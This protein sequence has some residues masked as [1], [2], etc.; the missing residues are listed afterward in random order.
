MNVFLII[1]RKLINA[2]RKFRCIFFYY[3]NKF[4]FIVKGVS[5]GGHLR[6][7][8]SLYIQKGLNSEIVI[9]DNFTFTSGECFNPLC[10][11][12]RGCIVTEPGSS[13]IIGN[14]VG[15]SSP[16][17]WAHSK[18]TIGNR[19]NIGGDCILMDSDAHSLN[20][21]DRRDYQLD[22]VNKKNSPISIGDDV[23]I[24]ARC[25]ILKGVTIGERSVIGSGSVVTRSI[26]ADCI[27]GGNPCKIIKYFNE[28]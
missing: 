6:V 14:N 27:A 15:M 23:L 2:P 17:V 16:C 9:G 12:V 7:S 24:G 19:V 26:P 10:R 25:I 18:I 28:E 20:Y 3:W 21:L 5:F 4:I 8:S 22:K 11:N 13:I 1:I